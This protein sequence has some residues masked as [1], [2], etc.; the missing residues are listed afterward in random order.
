MIKWLILFCMLVAI[1]SLMA[2]KYS[3][4]PVGNNSK[5]SFGDN[6]VDTVPL[7]ED[8]S[9][10]YLITAAWSEGVVYNPPGLFKEH[11]KSTPT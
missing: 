10:E 8:I 7:T 11:V 9:F 5:R 2:A 1:K 3:A 6:H 4:S